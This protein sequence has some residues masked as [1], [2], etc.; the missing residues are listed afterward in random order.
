MPTVQALAVSG[1]RSGIGPPTQGA[2]VAGRRLWINDVGDKDVTDL[3][4]IGPE[5]WRR[6]ERGSP[7]TAQPEEREAANSSPPSD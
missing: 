3:V 2:C 6:P 5:E 7:V 1:C 4:G